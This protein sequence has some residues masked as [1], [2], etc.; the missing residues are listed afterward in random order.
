MAKQVPRYQKGSHLFWHGHY[1]NTITCPGCQITRRR[2][3]KNLDHQR[4]NLP[5]DD[6]HES[7]ESTRPD[8][9]TPL[10]EGPSS[11]SLPQMSTNEST[12]T[13][14]NVTTGRGLRP[15]HSPRFFTVGSRGIKVYASS[16]PLPPGEKPINP[17]GP[18]FILTMGSVPSNGSLFKHSSE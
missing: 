2:R 6:S 10:L 3:E 14:E 16:R 5:T 12:E 7:S 15:L 13:Q 17:R 8:V 4:T 11:P 18:G 1:G 9:T